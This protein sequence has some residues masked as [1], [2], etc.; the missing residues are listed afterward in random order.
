ML[1]RVSGSYQPTASVAMKI[2]IRIYLAKNCN[3]HH[4]APKGEEPCD[5]NNLAAP[6]VTRFVSALQPSQPSRYRLRYAPNP[7]EYV[8]SKPLARTRTAVLV[9]CPAVLYSCPVQL[10]SGTAFKQAL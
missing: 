1:S 6:Q 3:Y 8:L 7:A 10:S 2:P 9:S 5:S 4:I